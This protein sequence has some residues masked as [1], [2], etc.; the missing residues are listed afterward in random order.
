VMELKGLRGLGGGLGACRGGRD[1]RCS[2]PNQA[3]KAPHTEGTAVS[4][5]ERRGMR[6]RPS[7]HLTS[8]YT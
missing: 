3:V 8:S 7:K 1:P 6:A 2:I 4:P 5:W